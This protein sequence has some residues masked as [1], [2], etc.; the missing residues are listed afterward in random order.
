MWYQQGLALTG[1]TGI[2][3]LKADKRVT[4]QYSHY[5]GHYI[6]IVLLLILHTG[7]SYLVQVTLPDW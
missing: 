6:Y 5:D 7:R 1:T 4:K 2:R 3:T